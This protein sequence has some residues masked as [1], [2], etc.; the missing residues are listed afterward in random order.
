MKVGDVVGLIHDV[1]IQIGNRKL[2][3]VYK[4]FEDPNVLAYPGSNSHL[5]SDPVLRVKGT[6][7][8]GTK[9]NKNRL[10][11]W[12]G[13]SLGYFASSVFSFKIFELHKIRFHRIL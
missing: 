12:I 13:D 7:N 11:F 10:S 3:V 4:M 9:K 5:K 8:S 2:Y 6:A 1:M